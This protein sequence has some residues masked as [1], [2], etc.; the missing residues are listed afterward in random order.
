MLE[1]GCACYCGVVGVRVLQ[2]LSIADLYSVLQCAVVCCSALWVS[3]FCHYWAVNWVTYFLYC[4]TLKARMGMQC[5]AMCC[6]VLRCEVVCCGVLRC[7]A[8]CCGV[9]RCVAVCRGVL[10]CV[11]VCC[12]VLQCVAVHRRD[13]RGCSVLQC[14]AVCCNVLHYAAMFCGV[15]QGCKL[16]DTYLGL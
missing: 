7:V 14:A 4:S 13:A 2:C 10:R 1:R 11:A 16:V 8:V 6:S 5:V 12:S 15:L 9:M 3:A